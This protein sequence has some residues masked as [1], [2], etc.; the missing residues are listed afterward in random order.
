M[1]TPDVSL[2]FSCRILIP[3]IAVIILCTGLCRCFL[4]SRRRRQEQRQLAEATA[5]AQEPPS[6]VYIIPF[7]RPEEQQS[8]PMRYGLAPEYAAPPPYSELTA[9]P[10]YPHDPPPAYTDYI[11]PPYVFSDPD[12]ITTSCPPRPQ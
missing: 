8:G 3:T 12:R 10:D 11:S 2:F 7:S 5:R 6:S 9:K 1:P 4:H